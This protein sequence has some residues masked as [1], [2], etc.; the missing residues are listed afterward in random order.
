MTITYSEKTHLVEGVLATDELMPMILMHLEA[1]DDIAIDTETSGL[2]VRNRVDYLMGFCLDVPGLS[3]YI[4][5]R[6]KTGNVDRKWIVPLWS[7]LRKKNLIWHN[8]KFDFHSIASIGLNPLELEGLQ[9]DTLMIAALVNENLFSKELDSL[10]KIAMGNKEYGKV[11]SDRVHAHGRAVGYANIPPEM[12]RQYGSHDAHLTRRVRDYF[13]P[14]LLEQELDTVY[15]NVESRF[16]TLLYIMEQR[17]VGVNS[18]MCSEY[19]ER[20]RSRMATIQRNLGGRNPASP[21]D[22]KHLLLTE[23][24][25]P[26]LAH[27]K[28]C[29]QCF[30]PKGSNRKSI[31]VETHKGPPSF[32]KVVMEEYD[33]ILQGS[34]NPTAQLV[35]EYRGWQKAVTALYEP[36]MEKVGPDGFLRTEFQQHRTVTGRLSSSD[37]NLQQVPRHTEKPWNG[38]AKAAFHSGRDR[39]LLYGWDWSQI[40]LRLSAAYAGEI[41]LLAE[42][43]KA[44]ADVFKLLTPRIFGTYSDE[45]RHLT[46]NK[47]VYPS[48]YG[49]QL[50]R[51]ALELGY[52]IEKARPLYENYKASIPSITA[53]SESVNKLAATRK[54]I[55]YWDGRRRHFPFRDEAHKAW[56]SLL[57]G[58]AAQLMKAT[59]LELMQYE[60]ENFFMVLT[61][62]DEI[63]FA[64]REDMLH[65]YD[66]IVV[67]CMTD[68]PQFGVTLACEGKEW[69]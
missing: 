53:L 14:K 45:L 1:A 64:V 7:I 16:T 35:A 25:L 13:W 54:F 57:Q 62:H 15:W 42:F 5:F 52:P 27:T 8:R 10:A 23:L 34:N 63:T 51:V 20:G 33:E 6:H 9:Y 58:G 40:E 4:P 55:K 3:C 19:S 60:D 66:P 46:K 2:N 44:D 21:L 26:V 49:A 67:K 22:L 12:Y 30:P 24:E 47:F 43:S 29:E 68:W 17:G 31:P 61:V 41:D 36:A 18:S 56:N 11:D 48:L 65:I 32:N 50:R 59:M 28:S 39:Y 37:P 69:K 38:R